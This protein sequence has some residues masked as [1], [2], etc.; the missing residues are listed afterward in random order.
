MSVHFVHRYHC[1]GPAGKHIAHFPDDGV[2]GVSATAASIGE[3]SATSPLPNSARSSIIVSNN[4][5]GILS[6]VAEGLG[7]VK[8]QQPGKR[9]GE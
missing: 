5:V 9:S 4:L 7:P 3:K 6:R 8:P 1:A 2:P